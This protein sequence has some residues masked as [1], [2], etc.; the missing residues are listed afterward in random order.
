[1]LVYT[2]LTETRTEPS[3][4]GINFPTFQTLT[5]NW[6]EDMNISAHYMESFPGGLHST[7]EI[8]RVEFT[9]TKAKQE[10]Q[11]AVLF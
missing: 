5:T 9:C 3:Y 11:K 8:V 6:I 10:Q 1:M 2:D 7:C 4:R